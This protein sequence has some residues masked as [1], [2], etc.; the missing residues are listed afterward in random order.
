MTKFL[1]AAAALALSTNAA[2]AALDCNSFFM[3]T[4][5]Q[6]ACINSMA[7]AGGATRAAVELTCHFLETAIEINGP[8]GGATSDPKNEKKD[9]EACRREFPD[10]PATP[11]PPSAHMRGLAALDEGDFDAA[12]AEFTAEI[13]DDPKDPFPYIRRGTAYEKKGDAA[14]AIGDYRKVLKLV[15]AETG[16][17]YAARIMKL[18]RAKK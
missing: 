18:E 14:A 10:K 8:G 3:T 7:M 9:M 17:E 11:P 1:L 12:I 6:R 13:A 5:V 15:D 16:A 4:D 2:L